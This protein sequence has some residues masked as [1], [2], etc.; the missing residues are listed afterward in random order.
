[1][2]NRATSWRLAPRLKSTRRR[3]SVLTDR[4]AASILATRDWLDPQR[5]A[6]S[7]W[8]MPRRSRQRRRP[9]ARANFVSMNRC[10][11]T[12]RSKNAVVSPTTQPS[13]SRRRRLFFSTGPISLCLDQLPKSLTP[14]PAVSQDR[15]GR[16]G[17]LLA[18]HLEN[19]HG[20]TGQVVHD[21]PRL[22]AVLDAVPH[23]VLWTQVNATP[24][25]VARAPRGPRS[26][27][28]TRA[29]RAARSCCTAPRTRSLRRVPP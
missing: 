5:F 9:V 17:R 14:P 11:S 26:A 3:R 4:S 27:C 10:S 15:S 6:T 18:E 20:I 12:D 21:A 7:V 22:V 8:V 19:H 23:P 13:R 25:G 1:M 24:P 28:D 16:R 2:S 29:S